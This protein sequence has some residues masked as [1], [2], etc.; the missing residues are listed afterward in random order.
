MAK[1]GG[2]DVERRA[3]GEAT[4]RDLIDAGRALFVSKGYFNTSIGL[5]RYAFGYPKADVRFPNYSYNGEDLIYCSAKDLSDGGERIQIPCTMT[6]G[7]SGGPWIISPNS[8]WSGYVNSV[9]SH[10]SW[11][12]EWMGGPYFGAAESILFQY[13]RAR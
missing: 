7:A 12:G 9:N 4:R 8:S 5:N 13:W 11:G 6:G 2:T 10:K 1:R 3:R